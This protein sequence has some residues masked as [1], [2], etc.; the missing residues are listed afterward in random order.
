[1]N[2]EEI[3]KDLNNKIYHPVY[4][5]QGEEPYF[6][7]KVSDYI[8][9]NVLDEGER[10]FNQTIV[11]GK[12]V[13]V[14]TIADI[15]MRY[16]MMSNYQVVILKEAQQMKGD[17]NK[18][19]G[20]EKLA[21]YF[22]N[23]VKS[24]I[25]VVNY[26]YGK[27][28][29]RTKLWKDTIS[30]QCVLDSDKLYDDK[31]PGFIKQ[32][33]I[34]HEHTIDT[35]AVETLVEYLG[36]DLSKIENEVSKLVLNVPK[37]ETINNSHIEKFIGISKDYNIFELQK[38]LAAKDTKKVYRIVDYYINNPK[39]N[40]AFLIIGTLNAF[41]TK[42]LHYQSFG[43]HDAAKKSMYL[44]YFQ[45]SDFRNFNK[46]YHRQQTEKIFNILLEYDMKVKGVGY[47]NSEKEPLLN[48][49]AY[50]ILNV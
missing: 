43:N 48:E 12:D 18:N 44:N 46:N 25:F 21:N 35:Q 22:S 31:L 30:K 29:K 42:A 17:G 27:L 7:D 24:T 38:A 36:N 10:S 33:V 6:I 19:N 2:Y 4:F 3:L 11:Y 41:F 37:T 28:D 1:M 13:D 8:Q 15:L 49:L 34:L 32:I 23:P 45:E 50:K 5:L 9:D 14:K 40:P 26:K 39:E 16:P 20:V 47:S